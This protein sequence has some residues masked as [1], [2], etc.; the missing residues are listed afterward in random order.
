MVRKDLQ[1]TNGM[2]V[3]NNNHLTKFSSNAWLRLAH[4]LHELRCAV[5]EF[6]K[7]LLIAFFLTVSLNS[8]AFS[9]IQSDSIEVRILNQGKHDLKE[10]VVTIDG[11][12]YIFEKIKKGAFSDY[13]NMPYLWTTNK[14]KTTVVVKKLIRPDEW[15]SITM[16]P[17]DYVGEEKLVKGKYLIELLTKK[18]GNQLEVFQKIKKE[19]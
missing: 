1:K 19:E 4:Q 2:S 5:L 9:L 8:S 6:M 12:D 15:T 18:K 16:T 17:I 3:K 7:N 11:H 14:T 13:K 10:Y